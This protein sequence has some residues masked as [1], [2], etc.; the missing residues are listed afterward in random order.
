MAETPA[1][2][3]IASVGAGTATGTATA[4]FRG[5]GLWIFLAPTEAT[6]RL[7]TKRLEVGVACSHYMQVAGSRI[8]GTSKQIICAT[9]G[10]TLYSDHAV[11]SNV[12]R[13][14][15]GLV[16]CLPYPSTSA[17]PL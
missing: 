15:L 5:L 4:L 12:R 14:R 13:S 6:E 9:L 3:E 2:D 11:L 1:A 10:A 17:K 8:P 7:A 16:M